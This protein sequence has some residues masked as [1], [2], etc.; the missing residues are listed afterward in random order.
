MSNIYD[1][2]RFQ[3]FSLVQKSQV[4]LWKKM[5][6]KIWQNF[7]TLGEDKEMAGYRI[8]KK[9]YKYIKSGNKMFAPVFI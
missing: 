7:Y 9:H 2:Q 5:E 6:K 8:F 4:S 1:N 3:D